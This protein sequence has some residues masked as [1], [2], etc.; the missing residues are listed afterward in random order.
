MRWISA[1]LKI[2]NG[3]GMS[4]IKIPEVGKWMWNLLYSMPNNRAEEFEA[5]PEVSGGAFLAVRFQK[6]LNV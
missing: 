3:S 2:G 5:P 6:K 1:C 4:R